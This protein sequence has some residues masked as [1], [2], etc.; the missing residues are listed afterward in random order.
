MGIIRPSTSPYNAP[1]WVVPKKCDSHGNPR[2]RV[3]TDFRKLNEHTEMDEYPLPNLLSI[4]DRI[5][6]AKYYTKLDLSSGFLHIP[7]APEDITKTAIS[8][9]NG[10][11]EFLKMPFGMKTAPKT[12]QRA[13]DIALK[14]LI[15]CGVFVY[16]DDIIIY[17]KTLAEHNRLLSEVLAR[18]RKHN[19]KLEV[20]KCEF[21][22]KEI[23]YLG[24]VLGPS[25]VKVDPE[26][27]RAVKEFP[28]PKNQK[29]C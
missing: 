28:T 25:G 4:F 6:G 17:A 9:D 10:S 13:M 21:L 19:F 11:F 7:I 23:T 22:K 27:I 12:F 8:T 26:K 15:G 16:M 14:G 18:L 20:D 5:G 24:H 29:K 1:I 3:V 2:W